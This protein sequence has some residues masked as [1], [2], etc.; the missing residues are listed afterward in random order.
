LVGI[1]G[2]MAV[3]RALGVKDG[4]RTNGELWRWEGWEV[5]YQVSAGKGLHTWMNSY[6]SSTSHCR[7]I[8]IHG[9]SGS[10]DIGESMLIYYIQVTRVH[11]LSQTPGISPFENR[12]SVQE[13]REYRLC[14]K[15]TWLMIELGE[16]PNVRASHEGYGFGYILQ[17]SIS[18][19]RTLFKPPVCGHIIHVFPFVMFDKSSN[20]IMM[21]EFCVKLS[22]LCCSV[23]AIALQ[24]CP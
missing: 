10:I 18:K 15:R 7:W 5:C 1:V 6:V 23:P 3:R 19:E 24:Q 20:Q 22:R 9:F 14:S 16:V 17:C 8:S 21:L 13:S 4:G 11:R 2:C 12:W